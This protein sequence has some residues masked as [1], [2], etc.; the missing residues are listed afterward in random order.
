MK[1]ILSENNGLVQRLSK[2]R[3]KKYRREERM[4]LVEGA[5]MVRE[6]F[7]LRQDVRFIALDNRELNRFAGILALAGES[8]EV[9]ALPEN[10]FRK[11]CDTETPQGILAAI[12]FPENEIRP[13]K[14]NSLILDRI[15]DPGNLGTIIRTAN[16]CGYRE[17]YLIGCVEPYNPKVVRST[18]SGIFSVTLYECTESQAMVATGGILRICADMSGESLFNRQPV[19]K[20][21][22]V[23]GSESHG[24]SPALRS[25]CRKV[26]SLPMRPGAES[27]NAAVAAGI[28]M[29]EL[30]YGHII[31]Q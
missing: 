19:G 3:D 29:Y 14:G 21:C 2:L 11:L 5:K 8:T 17:L 27:L 6:A 20:H 23:I 30:E 1:L 24:V 9:L 18:M 10:V 26:Y 16:A 12:A 4:Y 15:A 28:F 25:A 31:R 13:P 22:I 7:E